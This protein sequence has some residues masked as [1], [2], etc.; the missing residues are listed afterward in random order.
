[1]NIGEQVLGSII[2][3]GVVYT[4]LFALWLF[5]LHSK[6]RAGPGEP[7]KAAANGPPSRMLQAVAQSHAEG[8]SLTSVDARQ[9]K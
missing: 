3:F 9:E 7:E 8:Q 5:V 6:I 1:M 2:L 4:G